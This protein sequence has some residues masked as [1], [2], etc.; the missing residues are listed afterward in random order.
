M[1]YIDLCLLAARAASAEPSA[2]SAPPPKASTAKSGSAPMSKTH[3]NII[4][5]KFA[6][7]KT[8]ISDRILDFVGNIPFIKFI[9]K[10]LV[11]IVAV[12]ALFAITSPIIMLILMYYHS[13]RE[14]GTF[15]DE[16]VTGWDFRPD[17]CDGGIEYKGELDEVERILERVKERRMRR[18]AGLPRGALLSSQGLELHTIKRANYTVPDIGSDSEGENFPLLD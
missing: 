8:T 6:N 13:S 2:T 9:T 11:I 1:W 12:V 5:W 14:E 10:V 16:A 17:L 18:M 3:L 4:D 7:S 15:G